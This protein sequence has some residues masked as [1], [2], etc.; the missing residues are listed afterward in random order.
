LEAADL[1]SNWWPV[2]QERC[3][4][5]LKLFKAYFMQRDADDTCDRHS[6]GKREAVKYWLSARGQLRIG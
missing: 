4:E 2:V 5:I 6:Q 1:S 3:D